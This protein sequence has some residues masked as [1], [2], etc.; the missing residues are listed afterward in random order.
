MTVHYST[1]LCPHCRGVLKIWPDMAGQE[2]LC[3]HCESRL[4]IEIDGDGDVQFTEVESAEV[5][6]CGCCGAKAGT[7]CDDDCDT[8]TGDGT[9]AGRT[10]MGGH[11]NVVSGNYSLIGGGDHCCIDGGEACVVWGRF[12]FL[13]DAKPGEIAIRVHFEVTQREDGFWDA[14]LPDVLGGS[15]EPPIHGLGGTELDALLEAQTNLFL[16]LVQQR[17]EMR[18][19]HQSKPR[20]R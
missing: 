8:Q 2:A 4:K 20:E 9:Y 15:I 6:E 1:T 11:N 12:I 7:D 18:Q 3:N 19:L 10:I 5:P 13:E 16:W 14:R 17:R